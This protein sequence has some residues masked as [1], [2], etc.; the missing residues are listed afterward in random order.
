MTTTSTSRRTGERRNEPPVLEVR[1]LDVSFWVNGLWFPA[2]DKAAF[3]LH[4]GEA[5]AIVGESGSG[6]STIAL[7][8]MGLLPKNASVRGSIR[9]SGLEIVGLDER[10]LRSI[11]GRVVSMIFQEPMTALNP[12]YTVGFQIA[13]MLRSHQSM[14]PRAARRRAIE[15]LELVE[16][17]EPERRVDSL[18]APAV[19]RTAPAGDDRPG[20]GARSRPAR[21]RRAND[22][23]RRHRAGRDPQADPRSPR[24]HRRRH[25]PD[26]P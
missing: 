6:K 7:A 20:A 8:L 11:R 3:D 4:A 5:L 2:V 17:P 25:P 13:E 14:S 19:G 10:G 15:L 1:D 16:I 18:P 9:L 24:P 12:V 21:R 22:G 26:H 23:A